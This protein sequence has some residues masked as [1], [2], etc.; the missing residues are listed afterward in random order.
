MSDWRGRGASLETSLCSSLSSIKAAKLVPRIAAHQFD[1]AK[2]PK[3]G[4]PVP[5]STYAFRSTSDHFHSMVMEGSCDACGTVHLLK[6]FL[7]VEF[8]LQRRVTAMAARLSCPDFASAKFFLKLTGL[9]STLARFGRDRENVAVRIH[10]R[11]LPFVH[12]EMRCQMEFALEAHEIA[13]ARQSL[14]RPTMPSS[15]E[16]P[17]RVCAGFLE[18]PIR[19]LDLEPLGS[20]FRQTYTEE[21]SRFAGLFDGGRGSPVVLRAGADLSA[22]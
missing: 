6:D 20:P 15:Y 10:D 1:L 2:C 21:L 5:R 8:L 4:S 3:C 11:A 14:K 12:N 17:D 13:V 19:R 9:P 16:D 18:R 22:L 7:E